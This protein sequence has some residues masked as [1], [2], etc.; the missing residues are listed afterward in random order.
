LI[1]AA[2]VGLGWWGRTSVESVPAN[3]TA[4]RFTHGVVRNPAPATG[5]AAGHGM[6]L[7]T[8]LDRVL[9]DPDVDAVVLVTP[10][11]R[12]V[13]QIVAA[14]AASMPVLT[15]K[16]LA[17]TLAGPRRA[18]DACEAAGVPLGIG[19]DERFLP[20]FASSPPTS[21]RDVSAPCCTSKASTP[22]TT[23]RADSAERGGRARTRPPAPG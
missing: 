13:E 5:F 18:V 19:T 16:P 7:T 15:E 12:H 14:A 20:Q 6:A 9:R 1:R 10:H 8:D 17:L 22:T 21:R 23:A 3:S 4:L 2:L 11:S